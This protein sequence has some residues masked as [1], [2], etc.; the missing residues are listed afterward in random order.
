MNNFEKIKSVLKSKIIFENGYHSLF[1]IVDLDASAI[2]DILFQFKGEF[3]SFVGV[4]GG[5]EAD[6]CSLNILFS[7][8]LV[9]DKKWN[10]SDFVRSSA[11]LIQGGGGGQAF[12]ATAGGKN[13]DGLE[14]AL[15]DIKASL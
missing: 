1:E 9:V 5:K 10:A 6:K 8:N 11:K 15:N 3:E 13:S 2:K 4:L 7:D 14:Q 12:F